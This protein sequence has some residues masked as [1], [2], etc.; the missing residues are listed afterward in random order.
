MAYAIMRFEKHKASAVGNLAGSL[1]HTFRSRFTP[2]ADPER[3]ADN[4]TL[5]GVSDPQAVIE[6]IQA[7]YPKKIRS[8]NVGCYEFLITYSPSADINPDAYFDRSISWLEK[9]FGA[10]NVISVVRHNDETTPHIAAYVVPVDPETGNLNARGWTGGK[11][12][13]SALQTRFWQH[14]GRDL[15]LDR[16]IKGSKAEHMSIAHFY[17][18]N[19][20]LDE[21]KA[22]IAAD[23]QQLEEQEKSLEQ[24]EREVQIDKDDV[25]ER[26]SKLAEQAEKMAQ[27]HLQRQRELECEREAIQ[28]RMVRA[29]KAEIRVDRSESKLNEREAALNQRQVALDS[30]DVEIEEKLTKIL[31]REEVLAGKEAKLT[32]LE[33]ELEDRGAKLAGGEAALAE[34][35]VEIDKAGKQLQQRLAAAK[36]QQEAWLAKH[37]PVALSDAERLSL[38]FAVM[39]FK[40]R[41]DAMSALWERDNALALAVDRLGWVTYDTGDVT[42]NGRRVLVERGTAEDQERKLEEWRLDGFDDGPSGP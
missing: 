18:E 10:E 36:Q 38:E 20:T 37:Q 12:R 14:A 11:A 13:C 4:E 33:R 23:Q 1:A 39:P 19:Q 17:A 34:R 7:R 29:E 15:G 2:N 31:E 32:N 27:E 5:V 6:A 24:R 8:N 28:N 42:E 40:E 41:C 9:E 25:A 16:G 21:K 22:T 30:R 35:Q 3:I 26:E